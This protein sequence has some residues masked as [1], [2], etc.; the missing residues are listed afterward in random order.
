MTTVSGDIG[1]G[2]KVD[3]SFHHAYQP[4]ITIHFG[5]IHD[6]ME[7]GLLPYSWCQQSLLLADHVHCPIIIAIT[8]TNPQWLQFSGAV[9]MIDDEL[10]MKVIDRQ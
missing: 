7:D 9:V 8:T 2:A 10:Q 3:I 6:L 4:I 1:D 5:C